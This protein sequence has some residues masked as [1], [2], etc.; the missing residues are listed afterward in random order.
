MKRCFFWV[1]SF[2]LFSPHCITCSAQQT[3]NIPTATIIEQECDANSQAF[4]KFW[5]G[6][7]PQGVFPF[8]DCAEITDWE[9][10]STQR[11]VIVPSG[12]LN[13][14]FL[15]FLSEQNRGTATYF[16]PK[17]ERSVNGTQLHAKITV[18]VTVT[19]PNGESASNS[20]SITLFG[21]QAP[22]AP[23]GAKVSGLQATPGGWAYAAL[24]IPV[25][26]DWAESSVVFTVK[27]S[28]GIGSNDPILETCTTPADE[29]TGLVCSIPDW[30]D[31]GSMTGPD[32]SS[33]NAG[34]TLPAA[35]PPSE[36][37]VFVMP[38][39][40]FQL[41]VLP[42]AI[43]YAPLGNGS[44]AQS[45][46]QISTTTGQS[47]QLGNADTSTTAW[48]ADDKTT[49]GGGLTL[50]DLENKVANLGFTVSGTWDNSV[51]SDNQQTYGTTGQIVNSYQIGDQYT[52]PACSNLP[53][54]QITFASQ[55]F[56]C[57]VILAVA[58]P[59]FAIWDYPG[60]PLIQPLGS[61]D[62]IEIPIMQLDA[63][64]KSPNALQT[65]TP[66]STNQS[67]FLEYASG[68]SQATTQYIWLTSTDCSDIADLDEFYL[69][70]SQSSAPLAYRVLYGGS[71]S[72]ANNAFTTVSSTQQTQLMV[73]QTSQTQY[74]T[75]I[76][77]SESTNL[78]VSTTVTLLADETLKLVGSA[79][80]SWNSTTITGN[81]T[82]TMYSAQSSVSLQSQTQ[83]STAI[84]DSSGII[85]PV[86]I[87][88]DS[89]F[90]GIAVQDT[91][92]NFSTSPVITP[93]CC[94]V[95]TGLFAKLPMVDWRDFASKRRKAPS[96][97]VKSPFGYV[98]VRNQ[99]NPAEVAKELQQIRADAARR[100]IPR[101]VPTA[102]E[103]SIAPWK[104][105]EVLRALQSL[106]V[107][108]P[109]VQDIIKSLQTSKPP[110]VEK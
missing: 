66:N 73:G 74:T 40:K 19:G 65:P 43:V 85:V 72:T 42:V 52:L 62:T 97:V 28:Q 55:P 64:I 44:K 99:P 94:A 71:V 53:L 30:T 50:S 5:G 46:Y 61:A 13:F 4:Q 92:M 102:F 23:A 7:A 83:A 20:A 27:S 6:S 80:G 36:F 38:A 103:G 17:G 35:I 93:I 41:P 16:P 75:K 33:V 9:P 31:Q 106:K 49:Y 104:A 11:Y 24:G 18:T 54:N 8:S 67:H 22:D 59:Q 32:L 78:G 108:G 86:N 109:Q 10:I 51:E 2:L 39:V 107:Q 15:L 37:V 70:G 100:H 14:Q 25:N 68:P 76:T 98:I 12:R 79:S 96:Y 77:A 47:S 91:D 88:Q 26:V 101:S 48:T 34:L 3:S 58:N 63:C 69:T 82:G 21:S 84:Q 87:L 57:D 110:Q 56:W 95:P 89:I 105:D 1:A 60:G 29:K 90:Q 81:T 45:Q